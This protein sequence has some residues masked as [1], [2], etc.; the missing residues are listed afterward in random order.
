MMSLFH[1]SVLMPLPR[2]DFLSLHPVITQQRS[3]AF[4][5]LCRRRHIV[6][7]RRQPI[8]SVPLRY[9]SE[10]P[11][12]VLKSFTQTLEA[13]RKTYRSRFPVRVRQHQ[14]IDQV[15]KALPLDRDP[16]F[17]HVREV[18]CAQPPRVVA[19]GEEHLLYLSLRRS[20]YLHSSLQRAQLPIGKSP[21][22]TPL[23]ILKDR[24]RFQP[25]VHL[26]QPLHFSPALL[27]ATLP[28]PPP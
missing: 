15:R 23:Q 28:S 1:I 10:F 9:F 8:G 4:G 14:V 12:C 6:H 19:L 22:I 26:Q 7:C 3:V 2:L 5:E 16:Q 27:K 24:L 18:G 20:P 17:T 11:N 21:G 25:R 13:L